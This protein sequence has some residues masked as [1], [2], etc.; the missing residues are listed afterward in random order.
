MARTPRSLFTKIAQHLLSLALMLATL[1]AM[2][3]LALP[4]L[5]PDFS[6]APPSSE[7]LPPPD[8]AGALTPDRTRLQLAPDLP[9]EP[10]VMPAVVPMS[11]EPDAATPVL[12]AES[13]SLSPLGVALLLILAGVLARRAYQWWMVLNQRR[14]IDQPDW[15]ALRSADWPVVTLLVVAREVGTAIEPLVEYLLTMDYPPE[16]LR[17]RPTGQFTTAQ[18][19]AVAALLARH[20]GRV[21][22]TADRPLDGIREA[23]T[24]IVLILRAEWTPDR[25]FVRQAVAPF[26][27]PSVGAVLAPLDP[28]VDGH[29]YTRL[30][31]LSRA[32]WARIV[33]PWLARANL[34]ALGDTL[35]FGVRRSAVAAAGGWRQTTNERCADLVWRLFAEGWH[36]ACQTALW[37]S[38]KQRDPQASQLPGLFVHLPALLASQRI[39]WRQKGRLLGYALARGSR[40][41]AGLGILLAVFEYASGNSLL[42]GLAL[43]ILLT[44][45]L[46]GQSLTLLAAG[47]QACQR[48]TQVSL[49]PLA[50]LRLAGVGHALH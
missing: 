35:L 7:Q 26:F 36:S 25:N 34:P 20:P 29:P 49:L 11:E 44:E 41:L 2:P 37:V 45:A 22:P 24:D 4:G 3:A 23:D 13:L 17:I 33:A 32:A 30:R 9:A 8:V 28:V 10:V 19:G 1:S 31:Q 12:S 46:A 5:D 39:A 43:C 38:G 47:A 21:L 50:L 48:G 16:R 40:H 14:R 42:A 6:D 27:D 15:S 18:R